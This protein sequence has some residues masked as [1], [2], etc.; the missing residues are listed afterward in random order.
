MKRKKIGNRRYGIERIREGHAFLFPLIVTVLIIFL[1]R[2]APAGAFTIPERL[3]FELSWIGIP[4]GTSYLSI[5]R[6]ENSFLIRSRAMSNR[7]VSAFYKVDDRIE[8]I[9]D[10]SFTHSVN[11]HIKIR[12][13]STR[14]DREVKFDQAEKKAHYFDYVKRRQKVDDIEK[15]TFDVLSAFFAVRRMDLRVGGSVLV[16]LFD[17][18]KK[19]DLEVQVLRKERV[20]VPAGTFDTIVIK[21]RLKSEG[22]FVRKGDIFIWLTD[23]DTKVPVKVKT[24]AP[25]GSIAA[26][27][28]GG[29]Y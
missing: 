26:E 21:P 28:T 14:K 1:V 23:D 13:G 27:L 15:N 4:A 5:D 17:D 11:Y 18:R 2:T 22:I 24:N 3:E 8:S 25:V 29:A 16:K 9:V 6:I 12:E 10:E 20:T 7:F 19:Y